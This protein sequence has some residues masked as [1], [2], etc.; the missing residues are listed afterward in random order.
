M[1]NYLDT[2]SRSMESFQNI[3]IVTQCDVVLRQG[4]KPNVEVIADESAKDWVE[5]EVRN[6]ELIVFTRPEYYGF[7]LMSGNYPKVNIT[8]NLLMG[9][10]VLDKAKISSENMFHSPRIG[11][12]VKAGNIKLNLNTGFLDLAILKKAYVKIDGLCLTSNILIHNQGVFDGNNLDILEGSLYM[13]NG[14]RAKA[15]T[16]EQ[17]ELRMFG[18]SSLEISGNPKINLQHLD[19]DC[20][21]KVKEVKSAET[22]GIP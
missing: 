4:N 9:I 13:S 12:I 7:L 2:N 1:K 18:R 8:C 10:E 14:A 17:L 22:Y 15:F 6:S 16:T 19:D 21:I 20:S 5:Y 11:L 3:K